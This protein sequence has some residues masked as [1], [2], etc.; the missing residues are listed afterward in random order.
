MSYLQDDHGLARAEIQR[1][2]GGRTVVAVYR[3]SD[4]SLT[5]GQG[6]LVGVDKVHALMGI[7]VLSPFMS[8]LNSDHLVRLAEATMRAIDESSISLEYLPIPVAEANP[9]FQQVVK[10][11]A[12]PERPSRQE[13]RSVPVL[14]PPRETEIMTKTS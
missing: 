14:P 12:R 5:N 9:D 13:E 2:S 8:F 10:N 4:K 7:D 6:T 3:Y 1:V 11:G